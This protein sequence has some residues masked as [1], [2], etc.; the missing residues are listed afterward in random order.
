MGLKFVFSKNDVT[1][2]RKQI[3]ANTRKL[4]MSKHAQKVEE[5]PL[6][7]TKPTPVGGDG[8]T[9]DEPRGKGNQLFFQHTPNYFYYITARHDFVITLAILLSLLAYAELLLLHHCSTRFCYHSCDFVITLGDYYI[10][11]H[12]ARACC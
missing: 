11:E 10:V 2:Y 6:I 9:V 1:N 5:S 7:R 4:V 3:A 8:V 12:D